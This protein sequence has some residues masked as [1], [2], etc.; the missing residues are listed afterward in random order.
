MSDEYQK[1][2][3]HLDN[4]PGGYPPTESGIEIK[5]LKRLFTSDEAKVAVSLT[6]MPESSEATAK[7]MDRD[8]EEME[9]MLLDMS[10]K[11]LIFR[12]S[13][14]GTNLYSASQFVVGIWEYQVNRLTEGLIKDFNEYVP[15]L[16]EAQKKSKTK[17]LRVIPVSKEVSAQ[18]T[19]M[20]YEEAENIIK[21]QSKILVAD[22]IC[23]KEH[24]MVGE[25]CDKPVHVCMV[26][27]SGAFYYEENGLGETVSQEKALEI[28]AEGVEAGL[29]LQ[30]GNSKK[31]INICMCCGCCCQI[32]KNVK[33]MDTP[34]K[35][36]CSSF[37]A[38][39][40]SDEC[41]SCEV[42]VERCPMDA[43]SMDDVAVVDL[44]RCIGCGVCA[45]SCDFDAITLK[46]KD[47]DQKWVPPE[48]TVET[49]MNIAKERGLF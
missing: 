4:L 44:T 18:I 28:L 31:P 6:M 20:P 11:G 3:K 26:F 46:T 9:A 41:S 25:G 7:K 49:Y 33:K 37:Y 42:C 16:M 13:K 39:V 14:G 45:A 47:E 29:V 22:C 30:P 23:R 21:A 19:V 27:G 5:I 34:A 17:Q 8:H 1:L 48:N 40:D 15:Y 38:A 35:F 43:I 10:K 24:N 12:S 36:V 32:L 2:A